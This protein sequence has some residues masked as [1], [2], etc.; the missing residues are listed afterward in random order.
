MVNSP[1]P[2]PA[3]PG[4]RSAGAGAEGGAPDMF[5]CNRVSGFFVLDLQSGRFGFLGPR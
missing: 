3:T 5:Y 2:P 1:P 4:G